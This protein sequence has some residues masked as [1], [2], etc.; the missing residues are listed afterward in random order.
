MSGIGT[1]RRVNGLESLYCKC[2]A[3]VSVVD[4]SLL[5]KGWITFHATN[6][7]INHITKIRKFV[8]LFKLNI[9]DLQVLLRKRWWRELVS[10]PLIYKI[11]GIFLEGTFSVAAV[12]MYPLLEVRFWLY[13]RFSWNDWGRQRT[14]APM[15]NL[16]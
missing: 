11:G 13:D 10:A 3:A 1:P 15:C 8:Y 7:L 4:N 14:I 6:T 9:R 16:F 5:D 2:W 12:V